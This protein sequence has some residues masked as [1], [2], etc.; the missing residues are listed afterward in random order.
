MT[1]CH[2]HKFKHHHKH[3]ESTVIVNTTVGPFLFTMKFLVL[4][5]PAQFQDKDV[6][7]GHDWFDHCSTA[8]AN[9]PNA[10]IIISGQLACQ[11]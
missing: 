7:F 8:L 11:L 6:V 10:Q 2:T 3:Y 1:F 4:D 5:N 9:F